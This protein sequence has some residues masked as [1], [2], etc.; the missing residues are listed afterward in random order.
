[1]LYTNRLHNIAYFHILHLIF[2]FQFINQLLPILY[3]IH[4]RVQTSNFTIN[5]LIFINL[6]QQILILRLPFIVLLLYFILLF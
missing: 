6:V 5:I 2:I 4:R 3:Q 1:M